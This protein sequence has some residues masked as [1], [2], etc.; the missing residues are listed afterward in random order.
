M[1]FAISSQTTS[2][3]DNLKFSRLNVEWGVVARGLQD[4]KQHPGSIGA[5]PLNLNEE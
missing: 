3:D 4:V 5:A 1:F 2:H